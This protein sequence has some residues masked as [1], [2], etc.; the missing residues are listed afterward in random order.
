MSA[1]PTP[2]QSRAGD[3]SRRA[4]RSRLKEV[5]RSCQA[6]SSKCRKF[7]YLCQDALSWLFCLGFCAIRPSGSWLSFVPGGQEWTPRP[8][9]RELLRPDLVVR[10]SISLLGRNAQR[11][12]SPNKAEQLGMSCFVLGLDPKQNILVHKFPHSAGYQESN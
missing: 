12:R 2:Q 9:A 8:L 10:D 11:E 5:G 3:I 1:S 6:S 7:F 4:F